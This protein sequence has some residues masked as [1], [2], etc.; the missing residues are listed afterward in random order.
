MF[1]LENI[2]LCF[3]DGFLRSFIAYVLNDVYIFLRQPFSCSRSHKHT[4]RF[5]KFI[6]RHIIF[7]QIGKVLDY[8][9]ESCSLELWTYCIGLLFIRLK[10]MRQKFFAYTCSVIFYGICDQD[11][12]VFIFLSS[13]EFDG[14]VLRSELNC[15]GQQIIQDLICSHARA[16]CLR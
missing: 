2:G 6:R 16:V 4:L 14:P 7:G 1:S 11:V 5:H 3:L 15:I 13:S 8:H 9:A 12:S 10:N